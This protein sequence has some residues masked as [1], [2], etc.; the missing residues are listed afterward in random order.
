MMRNFVMVDGLTFA[1]VYNKKNLLLILSQL[2][3]LF[4]I[5]YFKYFNESQFSV[6]GQ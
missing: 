3:I 4:I 5:H 2:Y 1:E 6:F